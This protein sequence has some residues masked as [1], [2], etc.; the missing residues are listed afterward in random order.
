MDSSFI[1][2]HGIH[3]LLFILIAWMD[4]CFTAVGR[5]SQD[6]DISVAFL[7]IYVPLGQTAPICFQG[8]VA[9]CQPYDSPAGLASSA[10]LSGL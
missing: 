7:F 9:Q 5:M 1:S 3:F 2:Q 6:D 10:S 8:E 4:R